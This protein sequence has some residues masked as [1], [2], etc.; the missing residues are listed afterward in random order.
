[1]KKIVFILAML[2]STILPGTATAADQN[3]VPNAYIFCNDID[4]KGCVVDDKVYTFE[5]YVK[6]KIDPSAKLT[7]MQMV[8][9]NFEMKPY[10]LVLYAH[11]NH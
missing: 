7:G 9:T 5:D 2:A 3:L 11:V 6:L 10:I 8:K 1:M 4:P